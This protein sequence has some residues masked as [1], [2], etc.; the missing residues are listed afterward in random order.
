MGGG[1]VLNG[2]GEVS[3]M[4]QVMEWGLIETPI[5]LTNTISVGAVSD[6]V[7]RYMIDRYPGI[8]DEHDVIIPIV[9][10]CDDSWLN[11]I[12]GRHVKREHVLEAINTAVRRAGR[13][14]RRRRRHRDDHLRLQGRDR[15]LVAQ[16][17][18]GARRLHPGRAGDVEL[19]EDAQPA[20]RRPPRRRGARGEAPEHA[21][22][23]ARLRLDHRGRRHRRAAAQPPDQPPLQARRPRHRPGRLV[24]R[25]RLGRDRGR[26][27]DREPDPA[28]HA[29]DG[30]QDEDPPRSAAWT[31]STR[32]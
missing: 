26:L 4:T 12:A 27:L 22:A 16:A 6:G 14:G 28:P 29:E 30:L 21:P 19:R 11:D 3:G 7:V 31:R 23:R 8:G 24:R 32:R 15:H 9:G 17:P 10:E 2:A 20:R 18:R 25:P 13:R 1:F 5:F